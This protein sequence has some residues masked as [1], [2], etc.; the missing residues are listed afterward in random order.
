MTTHVMTHVDGTACFRRRRRWWE[1]A[2][3]Q[4]AHPFAV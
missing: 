4:V 2:K 3:A 1:V